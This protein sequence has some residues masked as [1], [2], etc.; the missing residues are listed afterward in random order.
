MPSWS[1]HRALARR[2][3][4]ERAGCEAPGGVDS[5]LIDLLVDEPGALVS[6]L[7]EALPRSSALLALLLLDE[8]L[9][10]EDPVMEH[11]WGA[12]A[13]CRAS[14][15]ALRRASEALAGGLG[16][17]LVDLHLALDY[18]WKGGGLREFLEWAE[19]VGIAPEVVDFVV[20][21]VLRGR[22]SEVKA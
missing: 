6:R 1:V 4:R 2:F 11:D 3:L 7:R 18:A 10:P 20:R 17:M 15:E 5:S 8:K 21:E 22:R 13:R 19:E 12:W 14:V 16:R 9:R